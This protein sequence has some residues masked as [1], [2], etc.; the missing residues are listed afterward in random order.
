VA[1][2][3]SFPCKEKATEIEAIF[4]QL[5]IGVSGIESD[6]REGEIMMWPR[7]KGANK[8]LGDR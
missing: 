4:C 2:F 1:V 8:A 5:Q 7:V 3:D 6:A